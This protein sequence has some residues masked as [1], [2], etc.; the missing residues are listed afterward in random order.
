MHVY[1]VTVV[2]SLSDNSKNKC[3]SMF[4]SIVDVC[5]K[6]CMSI[7]LHYL[8]QSLAIVSSVANHHIK[9][10]YTTD[11]ARGFLTHTTY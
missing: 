2:L 5:G 4:C 3:V 1:T 10:P 6:L 7:R 8:K 9:K 11:S